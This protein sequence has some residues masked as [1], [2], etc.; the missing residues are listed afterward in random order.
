MGCSSS[1]S[2]AVQDASNSSSSDQYNKAK[3]KYER[4]HK[5]ALSLLILADFSED[6]RLSEDI[7]QGSLSRLDK[8]AKKYH[9]K[10]SKKL[11]SNVLAW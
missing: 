1:R 4:N 10:V 11:S 2:Q 3:E 5:E 7:R 9:S 6:I 8:L